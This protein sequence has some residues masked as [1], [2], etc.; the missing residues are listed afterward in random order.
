TWEIPQALNVTPQLDMLIFDASLMQMTEVAYEIRNSLKGQNGEN[1]ILVGSEESPPGEGYVYNTF[2]ADLTANPGMTAAQ[3][4]TQIVN[5]TLDSYGSS[6]NNTQS[7]IDLSHMDDVATKLNAFAT[8]LILHIGD[9]STAMTNARNN[10]DHY[11]YPENKD[12][13]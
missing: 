13:W 4:G 6:G 1:G 12:L 10:A 7:C 2:L 11:A 8:S 3:L 9:S 5:R